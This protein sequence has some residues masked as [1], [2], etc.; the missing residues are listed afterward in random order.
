MTVGKQMNNRIV[1]PAG[2]ND[3]PKTGDLLLSFDNFR[4]ELPL[5]FVTANIQKD[6]PCILADHGRNNGLA[7]QSQAPAVL[8]SKD[9]KFSHWR[10]MVA[11]HGFRDAEPWPYG[12]KIDTNRLANRGWST[13]STN[14][15][16]RGEIV[17]EI[18]ESVQRFV[19]VSIDGWRN[20]LYGDRTLA[21]EANMAHDPEMTVERLGAEM[22]QL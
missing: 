8:I 3:F 1:L 9:G 17:E 12:T 11:E 2:P 21:N 16:T 5:L 14:H 15:E 22:E 20:F 10:W 7:G 19:N 18:P 6:P 13:S 4:N